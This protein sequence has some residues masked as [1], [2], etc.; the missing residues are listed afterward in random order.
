MVF[1][2][3]AQQ[4]RD[5]LDRDA[6]S[7]RG[8]VLAAMEVSGIKSCALPR[9]GWPLPAE[10]PVWPASLPAGRIVQGR[11]K[12]PQH[13]KE[14]ADSGPPGGFRHGPFSACAAQQSSLPDYPIGKTVLKPARGTTED[15][16]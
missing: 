8:A 5:R 11:Y 12:W 13:P 16:R 1:R 14:L 3:E 15:P 10:R 9:D 6:T 4:V 7:V 2:I